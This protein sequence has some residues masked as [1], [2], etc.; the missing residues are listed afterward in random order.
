MF[1]FF[2]FEQFSRQ[3]VAVCDPLDRFERKMDLEI[4]RK[5]GNGEGREMLKQVA[6]FIES[7][8]RQKY[9]QNIA[10]TTEF[11][12]TFVRQLGFGAVNFSSRVGRS[13]FKYLWLRG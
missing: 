1:F 2:E 11:G 6:E 13:I 4:V 3:V 5:S 7:E 9:L 8:A 12:Q 10:K